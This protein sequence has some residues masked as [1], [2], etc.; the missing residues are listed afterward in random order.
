MARP[1]EMLII[2]DDKKFAESLNSDAQRVQIILKHK[3][4][5]EDARLFLQ[6]DKGRKVSGVILD[7][8]CMKSKDQEVADKNFITAAISFFTKEMAHLPLAI[9][10]GEPDQYKELSALYKGTENVYSKGQ[11]AEEMLKFLKGEALKLDRVQVINKYKDIFEITEEYFDAET[12]EDLINCLSKLITS[13]KTQIKNNL[14]CIRRLQEKV[15]VEL[16]KNNPDL[17]PTEHVDDGVKVRAILKHLKEGNHVDG[18]TNNFAW[19]IYTISSDYGAHTQN[20]TQDSAVSKY[21]VHSAAYALLDLFLWF[22]EVVD[23]TR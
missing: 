21:T 1:L 10:T 19:S 22:R 12:E 11:N 18:K 16:N 8:V 20:R 9:L 3:D 13:D 15:Y 6:S 5:L 2:D 23:K 14:A 7:V 17:V 4:N